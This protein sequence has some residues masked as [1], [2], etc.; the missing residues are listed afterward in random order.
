MDTLQLFIWPHFHFAPHDPPDCVG[1]SNSRDGDEYLGRCAIGAGS[2]LFSLR[3][4]EAIQQSAVSVF[5][6]PDRVSMTVTV[7]A[8]EKELSFP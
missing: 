6:Q 8:Y 1:A 3:N 5:D 2:G 4:L 7:S